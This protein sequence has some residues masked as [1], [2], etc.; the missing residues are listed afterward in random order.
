MMA[1]S[2]LAASYCQG[3]TI[4]SDLVVSDVKGHCSTTLWPAIGAIWGR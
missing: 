4:R 3:K 1:S 2:L